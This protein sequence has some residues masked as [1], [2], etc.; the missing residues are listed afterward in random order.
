MEIR[1]YRS[2][3][4][5][6]IVECW[7]R[8]LKCDPVSIDVF[9][10]KV[11]LD[12]NFEPN[13][14]IVALSEGKIV[15]YAQCLIRHYPYLYDGLEQDK[16]WVSVLACDNN[17]ILRAMLT[18][19]DRYFKANNRSEVWFSSYTPNY[20]WPGV[21][22]KCY[23]SVYGALREAGYR[24]VYD[25]LAMD[26]DL[27]PDFTRPEGVDELE[28]K[29]KAEG[30][31]VHEM[32]ARDIVPLLNFLKN[33]FAA[34]WYRHFIE[35]CQRGVPRD[36]VVVATFGEEVVGYAQFWGNEGYEWVYAGEHFGPFGVK[37][38]LRGK[39]IGT[40]ILSRC[41]T[42]MKKKGIH[43]AF[44]LW[45]DERAARLYEKFGFKVTRR[46]TVMKKVL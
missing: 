15:G 39:G 20:F 11:L 18:E 10:R 16:G 13:G 9:E 4:E 35:L 21:D 3:D 25:A 5:E 27:W 28:D 14:A 34:D 12:P 46:F 32:R 2:G 26:A 7:N 24:D 6:G 30:Y 1:H 45:T 41:L 42:N 22:K 44:F 36:Q 8:T 38:S 37:E 19:A 33:N 17:A 29:L 40:V 23:P 31:D 43:R